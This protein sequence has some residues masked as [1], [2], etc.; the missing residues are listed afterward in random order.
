MAPS[1]TGISI[2]SILLLSACQPRVDVAAATGELL[3][4]DR[5]WA[6]LADA[7]GPVDSVVGTGRPTPE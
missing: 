4:T 1:L 3:A 2:G 6:A 5:A 7:N